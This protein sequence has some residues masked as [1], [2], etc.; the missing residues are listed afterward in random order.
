MSTETNAPTR[1]TVAAGATPE[2]ISPTASGSFLA[3]SLA[4]AR[5]PAVPSGFVPT[6]GTRYNG[7]RA[8]KDELVAL[9]LAIGDLRAFTSYDVTFGATA[10][11][12]AEV[13][14]VFTVT[15]A[16]SQTRN[17]SAAWDKYGRDQEGMAWRGMRAVIKRLKPL[18]LLAV[19]GDP[20]LATRFAGLAALL[21][22][23]SVTAQKSAA[24]KARMAID[25]ES[26][27][28]VPSEK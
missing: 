17:A 21:G 16:W 24:T 5:V 22:A 13:L 9:P 8:R 20:S 14:R 3:P 28:S 15:F 25:A 26:S 10:P 2:P 4:N 7:T 1:S 18:F 11:P 12:I 6:S 23:K 19:R 27:A